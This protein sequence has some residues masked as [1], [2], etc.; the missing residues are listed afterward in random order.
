MLPRLSEGLSP[1]VLLINT[2]LEKGDD[3]QDRSVGCHVA[4]QA[5]ISS[6]A[7]HACYLVMCVQLVYLYSLESNSSSSNKWVQ[8]CLQ[9]RHQL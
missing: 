5:S 7:T 4:N 8:L 9:S 1:S 3:E 2:E 6:N